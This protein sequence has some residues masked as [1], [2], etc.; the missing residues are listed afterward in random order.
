MRRIL[1]RLVPMFVLVA[2]LT[3]VAGPQVG[4]TAASA[5]PGPQQLQGV[6]CC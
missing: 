2:G 3:L 5:S 1:A 4:A 6:W